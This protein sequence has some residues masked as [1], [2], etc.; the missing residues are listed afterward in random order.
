VETILSGTLTKNGQPVS[1]GVTLIGPG[2]SLLWKPPTNLFGSALGIFTARVSD[3]TALSAAAWP[4]TANVA[5]VN[6]APTLNPIYNFA[7][8]EDQ[9]VTWPIDG[10][11][12]GAANEVQT[13]TI[14]AVSSDPAL[15]PNPVITYTSPSTN[16]G[17]SLAP[18]PNASGAC[19]VTVTVSDGT[20]TFSRTFS[21][22]V[23][24]VNDRPT[25]DKVQGMILSEDPGEQVILLTGITAGAS[26]ESQP[27]TVTAVSG[28]TNAIPHPTIEYTS[29]NSTAVL[30]FTPVLNTPGLGPI[31][32]SVSDGLLTSNMIFHV[33][34][35]PVNDP[36][37]INPIPTLVIDEDAGQQT[38][39][40][41]G[42]SAGPNENQN[43]SLLAVSSNSLVI[44]TLPAVAYTSPNST[45]T[46][47]F[48]P[49]ANAF[50]TATVGVVVQEVPGISTT[51]S[52]NVVVNPVNDPP[53][54]NALGNVSYKRKATST[55]SLA[56]ISAGPNET[57]NLVITA[58]SSDP[59]LVPHPPV[60]YTSPNSTGSL[61]LTAPGNGTGTATI[62]VTVND[63][64][65]ANNT[66]VRTLTVTV[67]K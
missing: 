33:V 5:P 12:S 37:T 53:T 16:A 40:L 54:L 36:P 44:P 10:I 15:L 29:P 67:I 13:L 34:V 9:N 20:D 6:D 39:T 11:S 50:G 49:V 43:L 26:N 24:A 25:I 2:Q 14:S 45:G 31:T 60:T 35:N 57:Q 62:T 27:L 1:P 46:L 3:G 52:F 47:T 8:N 66:V 64:Q 18:T 30:R 21:V 59:S 48:T 55:V 38:I 41:T 4:V 42:I 19:T 56:G 61:L 51:R 63:G 58:V 17:M 23:Y 65:S 7:L 28:Y 32:V 22:T